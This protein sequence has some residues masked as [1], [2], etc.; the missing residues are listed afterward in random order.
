MISQLVPLRDLATKVA[1]VPVEVV[2]LDQTTVERAARAI[3][4][5]KQSVDNTLLRTG[6]IARSTFAAGTSTS[7]L[8]VQ[9]T[10]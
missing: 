2:A 8:G 7:N 5:R 9:N 6:E 4:M 3:V 10:Y 1:A